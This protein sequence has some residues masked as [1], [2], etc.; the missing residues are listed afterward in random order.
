MY[1]GLKFFDIDDNNRVITVLRMIF[2]KKYVI[3]HIMCLQQWMGA[4]IN[5]KMK[6]KQIMLTG[7]LGKSMRIYLIVCGCIT[8]IQKHT[9]S[10]V[11]N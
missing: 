2:Q 9:M 8:E 11:M 6:M 1:L 4:M 3:M 7:S 5:L 10:S